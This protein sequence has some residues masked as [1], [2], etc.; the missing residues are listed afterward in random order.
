MVIFVRSSYDS[1]VYTMKGNEEVIIYLII[2]GDDIL[3]EIP[4]KEEMV[5]L[6]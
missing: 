5:S 4:R 3:M 6:K 1:G 2:Y